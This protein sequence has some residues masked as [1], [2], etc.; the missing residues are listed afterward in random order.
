MEPLLYCKTKT[1]L[2]TR[3]VFEPRI[4]KG[5]SL[6][7]VGEMCIFDNPL[8]YTEFVAYLDKK[9]YNYRKNR[10]LKEKSL[11]VILVEFSWFLRYVED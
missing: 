11:Q 2:W 8:F 9:Y 6:Q 7:C 5:K 1:W 10:I 3:T 4:F